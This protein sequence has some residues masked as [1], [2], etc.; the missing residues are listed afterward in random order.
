[1]AVEDCRSLTTAERYELDVRGWVVLCG[2]LGAGQLEQLNATVDACGPLTNDSRPPAGSHFLDWSPEFRSLTVHPAVTGAMRD[3][4][5]FH[6]RLDHAYAIAQRPDQPGGLHLHNGGAHF[7][8]DTYYF[9]RNGAQYSG[10][11][12]ASFALTDQGGDDGGFCAIPGSHNARFPVPD[13]VTAEHPLVECPRLD[14]GD[15]LVF[16]EALTHGTRP[17]RGAHERRAVLL[18]YA[19]GMIAWADPNLNRDRFY[20]VM[21]TDEQRALLTV[22]S[23]ERWMA[24]RLGYTLDD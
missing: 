20:D 17:W 3:L 18:K 12:V 15:L 10:L 2:V 22:P 6:V 9:A 19:P 13:G 7:W 8:G 23:I 1:M 24:P 16:S 14:A 5:H 11:T 4:C 21:D